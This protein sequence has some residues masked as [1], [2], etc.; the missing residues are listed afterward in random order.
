MLN[1]LSSYCHL[2]RSVCRYCRGKTNTS[3]SQGYGDTR[4]KK[5][6]NSS[7]DEIANV[8]F[9]YDNIVH[10]YNRLVHKFRYRSPQLCVGTHVY[11]IQQYNGHYAV[12]GHSR[13]PILVPIESSYTTSYNTNLPPILYRFQVIA[14]DSSNFR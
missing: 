6:R 9:L 13:S 11:Q 1:N 10:V 14:D 3:D 2:F 4:E 12:Q 7:G 8:K 5:T